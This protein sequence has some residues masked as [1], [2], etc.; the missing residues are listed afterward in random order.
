[1]LEGHHSKKW[2]PAVGQQGAWGNNSASRARCPRPA[3]RSCQPNGGSLAAVV[4]V[5]RHGRCEIVMCRAQSTKFTVAVICC[6][7]VGDASCVSS[8][9]IGNVANDPIISVD[10]ALAVCLC[11]RAAR[12]VGR[13][14]SGRIR[15][16]AETA[17]HA[18][19]HVQPPRGAIRRSGKSLGLVHHDQVRPLPLKVR[20]VAARRHAKHASVFLSGG[21]ADL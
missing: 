17:A 2:H 12:Q 1:M 8:E 7:A 16:P 15:L 21:R 5:A 18:L 9:R 11:D 6:S 10:S 4:P 19:G 3:A 20:H 14:H 13:G